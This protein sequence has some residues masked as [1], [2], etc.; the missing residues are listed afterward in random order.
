MLFFSAAIVAVS[1]HSLTNLFR[2]Q[3]CKSSNR[4]RQKAI[5]GE[6]GDSARIC[7][8]HNT[9]RS[10]GKAGAHSVKHVLKCRCFETGHQPMRKTAVT[11]YCIPLGWPECYAKSS[12]WKCG[13]V[14]LNF[15]IKRTN[16]TSQNHRV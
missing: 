2:F 6:N 9:V 12:A 16:E 8:P 1:K 14:E 5:S 4:G 3:A 13:V 10:H 7:S 11:F 15:C